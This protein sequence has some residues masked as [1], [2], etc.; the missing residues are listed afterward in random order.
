MN[1]PASSAASARNRAVAYWA[2][3]AI[4]AAE[5]AVGGAWDILRIDYVRE[6]VERQLGYPEY[7]L[8]IMGIWKVPGAV[9]LLV[10]RC[11]RLKEWAYAGAV[12]T[13]PA[14]PPPTWP[15]VTARASWA[16]PS[17][18]SSRSLLGRCVPR[19]AATSPPAQGPR[20]SF[21]RR[22]RRDD[23]SLRDLAGGR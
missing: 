21:A 1:A 15:W 9:V 2:T 19:P 11:P 7:F 6:I 13:T 16:R 12:F 3:T 17:S 10:P 8:V 4:I 18:P 22:S 14:R 20:S 23:D 5:L